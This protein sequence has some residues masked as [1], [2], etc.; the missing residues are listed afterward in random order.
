MCAA[1]REDSLGMEI[2]NDTERTHILYMYSFLHISCEIVCVAL[3]LEYHSTHLSLLQ[4]HA[5]GGLPDR[6]QPVSNGPC[7]GL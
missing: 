5:T 2:V 3:L 4:V 7:R 6:V 1:D